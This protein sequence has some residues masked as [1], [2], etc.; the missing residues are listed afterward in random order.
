MKG[1]SGC[2]EWR[3]NHDREGGGCVTISIYIVHDSRGIEGQIK[4]TGKKESHRKVILHF[5]PLEISACI[6]YISMRRH[7]VVHTEEKQN[8]AGIK[9]ATRD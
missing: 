5:C 6:I 8:E 4:Q 1:T 2:G 9:Q 3:W 7:K